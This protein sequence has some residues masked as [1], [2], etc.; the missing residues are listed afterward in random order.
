MLF[1]P[2]VFSGR[3]T[4]HLN[5][6]SI[7]SFDDETLSKI[8]T[9]ITDWHFAKGFDGSFSRSVHNEFLQPVKALQLNYE[10]LTGMWMFCCRLGKIMVQATMAVYKDAIDAFLPTPSKSHYIFNLRDF[11]RVIKGVLLAPATHLKA[12]THSHSIL[13]SNCL[14]I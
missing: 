2:N 4:R 9:S 7:D 11:S 13:M 3:F 8:F 6:V 14:L 10:R 5:V 1:Y 12:S